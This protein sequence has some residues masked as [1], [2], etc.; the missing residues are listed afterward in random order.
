[1]VHINLVGNIH[2][3]DFHSYE[4]RFVGSLR[5]GLER[6]TAFTDVDPSAAEA[7]GGRVGDHGGDNR[8]VGDD[9]IAVFGTV[10]RRNTDIAGII[11]SW[12]ADP[13]P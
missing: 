12:P 8:T 11:I 10:E 13:R 5:G 4:I 7:E 9:G 3:A 2:P 6:G 1:M